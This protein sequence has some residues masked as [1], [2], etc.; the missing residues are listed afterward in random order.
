MSRTHIGGDAIDRQTMTAS[1]PVSS[2]TPVK[3]LAG[4]MWKFHGEGY[5]V[6]LR[7]MG[8]GAVSQ[9][10]KAVII[11]RMMA[12]AKGQE[13]YVVP[14]FQVD[15]I[16]GVERT[17]IRFFIIV[18]SIISNVPIPKPVTGVGDV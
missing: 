9:A 2:D 4:A 13:I 10:V 1:L 14:T 12:S 16:G 18:Q 5:R 15:S 11:A 6:D 17:L 3:R 7:A 8:A